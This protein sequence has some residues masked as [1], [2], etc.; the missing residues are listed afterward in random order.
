MRWWE[1]RYHLDREKLERAFLRGCFA[2]TVDLWAPW[3]GLGALH[4]GVLEALRPHAFAFAHLSHFDRS[5]AC[6]Y[7]TLAGT[8]ADSHHRAWQAAMDACVRAGG[9]V[10]HHHG[11]GLAKLPWLKWAKTEEWLSLW[12]AEKKRRDPGNMFNA[13]KL[14]R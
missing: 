13:G 1:K 2:D 9:R 14:C 8:G 10:N 11:V 4:A 12:Q 6:L 5:G 3:E 7:V